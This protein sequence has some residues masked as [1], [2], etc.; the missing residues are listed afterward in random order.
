MIKIVECLFIIRAIIFQL[1]CCCAGFLFSSFSLSLSI[2]TEQYAQF[3]FPIS[4]HIARFCFPSVLGPEG[5]GKKALWL[6]IKSQNALLA[7]YNNI[8]E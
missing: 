5:L 4:M 7:P 2:Y 8:I 3:R 1:F 6:I